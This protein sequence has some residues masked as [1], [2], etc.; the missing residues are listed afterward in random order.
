MSFDIT[1]MYL[2]KYSQKSDSSSYSE[3]NK[4][5]IIDV[6]KTYLNIGPLHISLCANFNTFD[7]MGAC[8]GCLKK[9][10]TFLKCNFKN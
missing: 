1:N 6:C 10:I 8:S 3:S 5:C 9:L 2:K 7:N 4:K